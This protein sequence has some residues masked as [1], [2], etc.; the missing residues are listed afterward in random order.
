MRDRKDRTHVIKTFPGPILFLAGEKDQGIPADTILQQASLN[1]NA[2]AFILPDVAHMGMYESEG[3]S[4]KKIR[5][6]IDKCVVTSRPD[7]V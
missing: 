1:Q 5:K 4:L 6:F 7:T 2:E 3:P